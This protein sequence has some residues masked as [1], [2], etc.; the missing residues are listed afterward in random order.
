MSWTLGQV[1][2]RVRNL[3]DDPQ[4]SYLTDDFIIPLI[5]EV[6]SDANSQL[7]STQSQFDI[8]VVEVPGV[9][10]GTPNLSALQAPGQIL[11]HLAAQ[12]L[13]I[14]WKVGGL[15][16]SYYQLVENYGVLPDLQPQQGMAGWE[17]RSGIIWLT[18]SSIVVDLRVRAEFGFPPLV[19]DSDILQSHARIGYVVAY[20]TAALIATVRGNA[21]WQQQYETLA[22]E[23]MDEIMGQLTRA[24]QGQSRRI[25]RQTQNGAWRGNVQNAT[26]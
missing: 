26:Q 12:P 9:Q 11:G 1:K 6:Y 10:P 22:T 19:A 18:P 13:R 7:T 15:P 4:G 2:G 16:P 20:G 5:N 25:G 23:G 24:E 21:P 3:L 8:G 14:D 17:F